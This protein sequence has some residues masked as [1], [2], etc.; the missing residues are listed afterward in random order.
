MSHGRTQIRSA[1]A[2][3]LTGLPTTGQRVFVNRVHPVTEA[4]LPCISIAVDSE[5]IQHSTL[6]TPRFQERE[7]TAVVRIIARATASVDTILDGAIVEVESA[8]YAN[9]TL[10]GLARDSR[11]T[12]IDVALDDGAERPTG[13]A[14]ITVLIDWAAVEGSPQ[15]SV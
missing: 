9:R 15:I 1:L 11:V 2:A 13:V 8:I 12:S 14:G 5:R 10:T 7:L 4:E 3:A 6:R